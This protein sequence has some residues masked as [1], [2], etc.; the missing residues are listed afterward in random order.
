MP[1]L[2]GFIF[3]DYY[4]DELDY[5]KYEKDEINFL[6]KKIENLKSSIESYKK[7]IKSYEK[8][9]EFGR[10]FLNLK[11]VI[12]ENDEDYNKFEQEEKENFINRERKILREISILRKD[13]EKT[14]KEIKL[15]EKKL[16][17]KRGF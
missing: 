1:T 15:N 14:K 16:L 11:K 5:E 10:K 9:I 17:C 2:S 4:D 12:I 13:I 7:Q 3:G 6:E 8:Q